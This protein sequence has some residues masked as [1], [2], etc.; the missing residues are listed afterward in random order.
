MKVYVDGACVPNPGKGSWAVV[1]INRQEEIERVVSGI[2]IN[3]TNNL[4]ELR[5]IEEGI[6]FVLENHASIEVTIYSDSIYA[7]KSVTGEYN[8][9]KNRPQILDTREWLAV[10]KTVGISI[11]LEWV[12]G[13]SGNPGNE[14]ADFYANLLVEGI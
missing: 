11:N 7:I 14:A 3:T 12:K 5:A 2:C 9:K 13:H 1:V 4:M 6:R 8:G 10:A